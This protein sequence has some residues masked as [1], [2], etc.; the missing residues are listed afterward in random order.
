M[1]V[2]LGIGFRAGVRAAQLDA[3][4][5]AALAAYPDA[6][7]AVVATLAA[8]SRSRALRTL[9]ARRGWPLVAFERAQLATCAQRAAS[10][11]SAA[12]LARFGVAGV[13]EPCAQLAAPHGR[14]LAPKTI[15]DG[16]TVALAGP[17]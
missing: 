6:Q 11:P 1:R 16:V 13:A 10:A 2:A 4:V 17:L 5:R 12:A 7:P 14:L 15:R 8:K 9:C 3:A